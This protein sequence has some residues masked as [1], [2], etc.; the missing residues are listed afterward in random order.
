MLQNLVDMLETS[1]PSWTYGVSCADNE[2]FQKD[3]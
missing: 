1:L 2:Y 3:F